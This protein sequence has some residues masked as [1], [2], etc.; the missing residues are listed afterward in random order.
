MAPGAWPLGLIL[1]AVTGVWDLGF[2]PPEDAW[3]TT[4]LGVGHHTPGRRIR[5]AIPGPPAFRWS[6]SLACCSTFVLHHHFDVLLAAM[7]HYGRQ[8][9]S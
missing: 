8:L 3:V 5:E 1:G 7:H 6:Q 9:D 2:A 4:C